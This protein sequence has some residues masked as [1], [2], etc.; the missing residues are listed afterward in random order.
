MNRLPVSRSLAFGSLALI[1]LAGWVSPSRADAIF[2]YSVSPSTGSITGGGNTIT[3]T[4]G[5]GAGANASFPGGSNQNLLTI[6]VNASGGS[7]ASINQAVNFNVTVTD[8]ASGKST[9]VAFTG[10]ISGSVGKGSSSLS[11]TFSPTGAIALGDLGAFAYT[12]TTGTGLVLL[13]VGDNLLVE[14]FSA[15]ALPPPPPTTPEPTGFLLWGMIGLC[16][17]WYGRRQLRSS[18]AA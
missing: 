8:T 18:S 4:G 13:Q 2:S 14:N 6:N 12:L 1:A 16:G 5:S 11:F 9:T 3:I 10:N 7:I 17:L 15:V